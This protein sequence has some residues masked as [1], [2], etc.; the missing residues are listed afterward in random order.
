[1]LIEYSKRAPLCQAIAQTFD[2]AHPCSLCHIVVNKGKTSEKKIRSSIAG[3]KDRH[4]L[5][6]AV[7]PFGTT[8]H[9]FQIH[10]A[11]FLF[12]SNW[13]ISACTATALAP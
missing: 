3:A 9:S 5:R 6:I 13:A 10:D 7:G 8:V 11:R 1:M 2:G 12:F 4:H